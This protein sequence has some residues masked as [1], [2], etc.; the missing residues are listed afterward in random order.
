VVELERVE[1]DRG[2]FARSFDDERFRENGLV[3][4]FRQCNVSW[5][6]RAGTLRGLHYQT[7]PFAEAK[8]VRCTRGAI[9]DVIVDLRPTSPTY[10]RWFAVELTPGNGRQ[11]YAPEGV[12]HGFQTL[13]DGSEVLYQMSQVY[14]SEHA[15]GVRWDDPAFAVEWPEVSERIISERD[16]GYEEFQSWGAFS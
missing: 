6:A 3:P 12:A 1:D 2:W 14:S 11:L 5:N 15:R 16:R 8:L 9:Y 4:V 7:E 13:I 10:C